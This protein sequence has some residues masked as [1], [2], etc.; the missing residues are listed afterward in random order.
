MPSMSPFFFARFLG[1][2][3]FHMRGTRWR[4][5]SDEAWEIEVLGDGRV[6][7][8]GTRSIDGVRVVVFSVRGEKGRFAAKSSHFTRELA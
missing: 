5:A 7:V 6:R 3:A 8:L 1:G 2:Y 4:A